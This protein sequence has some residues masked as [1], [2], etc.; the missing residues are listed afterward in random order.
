MN[1]LYLIINSI[2][3]MLTFSLSGFH[4]YYHNTLIFFSSD[5]YSTSVSL[6]PNKNSTGFAELL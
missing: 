4:F 1:T 2:F 3:I 6:E 5:A